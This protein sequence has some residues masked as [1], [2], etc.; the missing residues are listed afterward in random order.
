MFLERMGKERE[1]L[2]ISSVMWEELEGKIYSQD[3]TNCQ[4][5]ESDPKELQCQ[6]EVFQK[7]TL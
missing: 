4:L 5:R 7:H 2:L 6:A 1:P 3:L